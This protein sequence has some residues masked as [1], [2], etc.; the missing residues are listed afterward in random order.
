[1][2]EIKDA[3]LLMISFSSMIIALLILIV[4]MSGQKQKK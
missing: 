2:M 1:M 4:N 3:L